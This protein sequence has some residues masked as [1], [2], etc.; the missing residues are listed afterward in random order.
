MELELALEL[1]CVFFSSLLIF[2]WSV[3]VQRGMGVSGGLFDALVEE[4]YEDH[5]AARRLFV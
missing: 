5:V 2:F 3:L 4:M 1:P